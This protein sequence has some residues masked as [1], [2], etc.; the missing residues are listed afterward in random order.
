MDMARLQKTQTEG[1]YSG[2]WN[3]DLLDLESEKTLVATA[4]VTSR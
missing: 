4:D 2:K 3:L 1:T